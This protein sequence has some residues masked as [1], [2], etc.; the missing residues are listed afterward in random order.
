MVDHTSTGAAVNCLEGNVERSH[1]SMPQ[2]WVPYPE[3]AAYA[4]HFANTCL[5]I[6]TA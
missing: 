2:S 3:D 6:C 1:H 4:L 5:I